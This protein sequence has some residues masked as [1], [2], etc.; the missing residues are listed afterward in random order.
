M[1]IISPLKCRIWSFAQEG[2]LKILLSKAPVIRG[3]SGHFPHAQLPGPSHTSE[4]SSKALDIVMSDPHLSLTGRKDSSFL[5][6]CRWE[7]RDRSLAQGRCTPTKSAVACHRLRVR[8]ISVGPHRCPACFLYRC[9]L[10][11]T[12]N[13]RICCPTPGGTEVQGGEQVHKG[14]ESQGRQRF[15][16]PKP[17]QEHPVYDIKQGKSFCYRSLQFF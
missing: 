7:N 11:L 8:K 2:Q 3:L 9:C 10:N 14:T 15:E 4:V 13:L 1:R 16:I 12:T 6:S 5:S 17:T